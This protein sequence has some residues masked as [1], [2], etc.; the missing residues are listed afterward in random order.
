[1]NRATLIL[2]GVCTE[3]ELKSQKSGYFGLE[4]IQSKPQFKEILKRLEEMFANF[5]KTFAESL[6]VRT[7]TRALLLT[8][9][10]FP[11]FQPGRVPNSVPCMRREAHSDTA[12]VWAHFWGNF[13]K[14]Q[15]SKVRNAEIFLFPV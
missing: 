2:S 11:R 3:I 8:T 6:R 15:Y 1:M 9:R 10:S 5:E 12:H 14:I 7:W 13:R 4:Q